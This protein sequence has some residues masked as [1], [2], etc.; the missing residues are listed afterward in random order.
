[1]N[2]GMLQIKNY[3]FLFGLLTFLGSFQVKSDSLRLLFQQDPYFKKLDALNGSIPLFYNGAVK[4]E[5]QTLLKNTGQKTADLLG[6]AQFAVKHLGPYFDSLG[7]PPELALLAVVN[8]QFQTNFVDPSNGASGVWPLTFSTAKRY[9]LITNAYVDQRR[10]LFLSANVTANYLLDLERIYQNWHFAIT[11]FYAGPINLNMAIR[12]AG[13]TLHYENVH[14][15][16]D[17]NQRACLEK[18]MALQYVFH[19]ASEHKINEQKF[20]LVGSDTVCTSIALSLDFIADKLELKPSLVRQLNPDFLEGIVPIIPG[21]NCF[22]LPK[23]KIE[24]YKENREVFEIKPAEMDTTTPPPIPLEGEV[25]KTPTG[26]PI[27]KNVSSEPKLIYYTVKSGDNLGLLAKLFDCSINE[28]KRWNAIS[29]TMLYAGAKI[30][31]YVPGNKMEEY[32]RINAMSAAQ[33]Q[34]LARRK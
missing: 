28:I 32:K 16:L 12:K 27:Q 30:K 3:I 4:A 26:V 9:K 21:C 22:R 17:E 6:K 20:N 5:I 25:I 23:D 31:V 33:K 24:V 14:L 2:C 29:G 10:N 13:N 18:F 1:M 8:S 7:L 15:A 11:A 19:F 34:A